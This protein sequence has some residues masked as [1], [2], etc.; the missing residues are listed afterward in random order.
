MKEGILGYDVDTLSVAECVDRVLD[1][2]AS[3]KQRQWLACIN[4]H[5]FVVS[6]KDHVF[7]SALKD[8]DW[9]I[10]DGVGIV[11]ASKILGGTIRQRVTG[12][13]VFSSLLQRLEASQ[14]RRVF[15]MGSTR[16][17]LDGIEARI[18]RDHPNLEVVGAYSPP[19]RA[20]YSADE[21]DEMITAINAAEPDVLLVGLTAPK[22]EKWIFKNKAR[23][24]VEFI[25]AA[26]AM[27]DYFAGT[28]KTP[29]PIMVKLGLEFVHRLAL[30]PRRLWRRT[31]VSAP[32][33]VFHI[34][35][36]RLAGLRS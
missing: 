29:S 6:T 24:N 34:V 1:G 12:P 8:A 16:E 14:H 21:T 35:R 36:A 3:G 27:F 4:P 9:L 25:G 17:T 32:V 31:F 5:S 15:F 28:L 7:A 19:F 20:V 22:Q 23:L 10:P 18:H 13:E 26:G 33:F 11:L 2:M 30:E